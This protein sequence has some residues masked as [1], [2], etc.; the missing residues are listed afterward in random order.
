MMKKIKKLS[1]LIFV[2]YAKM[3]YA[4]SFL[5]P[6]NSTACTEI[7]KQYTRAEIRYQT[8]DKASLL[9]IKSSPYIQDILQKYDDHNYNVIAYRLA[10]K[11]LIN[12]NVKTKQDNH[13]K[14]CLDLSA[15]IDKRTVDVIIK[16]EN[17]KPFAPQNVEKIVE[18]VNQE[19]QK[20]LYEVDNTIPLIYINDM[21]YYNQSKSSQ[22]TSIIAEKISLEPRVLVTENKEL[23]DYILQPKLILSKMEKINNENSKYSMSVVIEVQKVNGE[24]VVSQQQNRY[25]IIENKQDKQEIAHKL[26]TKLLDE[27]LKNISVKINKLNRV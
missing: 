13:E 25:I 5:L 7:T 1:V 8:Y 22:Y 21:E 24:I 27:A 14:I 2:I 6:V 15:S 12:V 20:T 23:A 10:D 17:I 19:I 16:N 26:L 3:S 9:A 4:D 11:A 18:N